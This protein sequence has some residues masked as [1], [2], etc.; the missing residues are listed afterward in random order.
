MSEINLE[1]KDYDINQ[2]SN[3]DYRFEAGKNDAVRMHMLGFICTVIATI[4]MYTFGTGDPAEMSY[5]LG[6]PMWISGAIVIYLIMFAVGMIYISR[7]KEFSL[8]ARDKEGVKK[9]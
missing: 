1:S 6:F 3:Y 2:I 5:F 7:W 4:W 9:S 8:A